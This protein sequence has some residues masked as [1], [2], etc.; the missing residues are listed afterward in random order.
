MNLNVVM[1]IAINYYDSAG[2]A[3]YTCQNLML[4]PIKLIISI[5]LLI[6]SI[7][8]LDRFVLSFFK[9]KVTIKL[10]NDPWKS[11]SL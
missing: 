8:Y 9:T 10:M 1:L 3:D 11:S 2:F 5:Y 7:C 4:T 6:N